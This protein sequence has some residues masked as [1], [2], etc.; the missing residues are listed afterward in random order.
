MSGI[1]DL[2]FTNLHERDPLSRTDHPY[3]PGTPLG[4]MRRF[5]ELRQ[6]TDRA[7]RRENIPPY[8]RGVRDF[9]LMVV[10]GVIGAV[11]LILL[12]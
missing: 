11:V 7:D 2:S 8:D 4:I 10:M 12:F 9:A 5:D 3:D 6:S 1:D